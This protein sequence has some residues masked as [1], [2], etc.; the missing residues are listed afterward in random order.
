MWIVK[1]T[2]IILT[3]IYCYNLTIIDVNEF[4]LYRYG[5]HMDCYNL[6]IIDVNVLNQ[7]SA[8]YVPIVIT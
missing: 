6:T 8:A 7:I 5:N 4:E 3:P 2:F 1:Y